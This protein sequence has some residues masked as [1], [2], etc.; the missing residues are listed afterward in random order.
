MAFD[1]KYAS[2]NLSPE[3]IKEIES[4]PY[5][6]QDLDK[7]LECIK[8]ERQS[9]KIQFYKCS[10]GFEI[11]LLQ[12]KSNIKT[13]IL[14][15]PEKEQKSII[16]RH[17]SFKKIHTSFLNTRRFA[18]GSYDGKFKKDTNKLTNS[19]L[20]DVKREILEL[21]GRM[22]SIKEVLMFLKN[23]LGHKH[24]TETVVS[25]IYKN[26]FDEIKRLQE[27]H[28]KSYD[29]LRL[30]A[31]TSRL[32]ELTWLYGKLKKKYEN[33][34]HREDHKALL[35][36]MESIRKEVEGDKLTL[37]G[38]IGIQVQQDIN[39]HVRAEIMKGV[40]LK[41]VILSRISA[42]KGI[43]PLDILKSLNDS[44]Y[45]KWNRLI[46]D[47]VDVEFEEIQFPSSQNYDFDNIRKLNKER[48]IIEEKESK[49]REDKSNSESRE[50]VLLKELL[51]SKLKEKSDSSNQ[52]KDN[53]EKII[54]TR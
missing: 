47:T 24:I 43:N 17:D 25:D 44:Y 3:E 12:N 34:N 50:N 26:N 16:N 38:N 36:T 31:K 5:E 30:T 13:A 29:H 4:C 48:E 10:D 33:S 52:K 27:K 54:K 39:L 6:I 28:K 37:Q 22:Y 45:A 42:N 15:L 1:I 18:F 32:E 2:L 51:L 11:N 53:I 46:N 23:D 14:H 41:E 19:L 49:E 40:A 7:F 8:L 35:Q 9:K 21:F 20:S